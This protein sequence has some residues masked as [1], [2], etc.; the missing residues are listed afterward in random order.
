GIDQD[1]GVVR[2]A[3]AEGAGARVKNAAHRLVLELLTILRVALLT[4]VVSV[5]TNKKVPLHGRI[6]GCEPV[7]GRDIVVMG[8]PVILGIDR[9][10]AGEKPGI[11]S[12]L[13]EYDAATSLSEP[14]RHCPST[15][16]GTHYD[17]LA[18]GPGVR[19]CAIIPVMSGALGPRIND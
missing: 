13:E 9:I 17:I 2:R 11:T 18:I 8:Q 10:A 14:R 15:S 4:L 16:A 12:G 5:V 1:H 6:F 3:S 7:E 19:H